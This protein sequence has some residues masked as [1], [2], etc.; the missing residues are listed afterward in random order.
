M[1]KIPATNRPIPKRISNKP[2]TAAPL[3]IGFDTL[4]L[5]S[6]PKPVIKVCY[7]LGT[8]ST[9]YISGCVQLLLSRLVYVLFYHI[10]VVCI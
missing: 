4:T 8:I 3:E 2:M 7:Y 1:S 6:G 10:A 9:C 5:P